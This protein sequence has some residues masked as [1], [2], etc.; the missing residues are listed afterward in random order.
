MNAPLQRSR[1]RRFASS[2]TILTTLSA[3]ILIGSVVAHGV[4][5]QDRAVDSRDAAT[6]SVP[7]PRN[8]G[9]TF[10]KIFNQVGPAVVNIN[11]ETLPKQPQTSRRGRGMQ[12]MNPDQGQGQGGDDDDNGGGDDSGNQGGG[13]N[14]LQDFFNRFFGGMPGPGNGGDMQDQEQRALGSGFIV[15]PRGYI[16]T[17]NH[18]VDKA[19][20]IYVK[21]TTDPVN[22]QGHL[23]KVIGVDTATDLAVIKIDVGHP[24]PTVQLGNSD[25][26]E[27]GEWVEAIGSPF[28]LSQTVTAGIVSAKNRTIQQGVAGQFQHFIQTD[29]AINPGNSG[30]PLLNMDGQVIGVNTAIFTQSNG[31]MG[32]GFAMPSNTVIDVYNQLIGPEHKVVRGSIGISFQPNINSAIAK[33]YDASSGVLISAVVPGGPADKA[34]LKPN[35]VIVSID[36]KTIKD[37][38]ELVNN[39][40]ARH[41]GSTVSIGYLRSG[42]HM[43]TT[44]T[45]V[46]RNKTVNGMMASNGNGPAPANPAPNVSQTKLGMSVSDLPPNAPS[47]FHGVLI[48]SIKPGSFADELGS[49][50]AEGYSGLQPGDIIEAVN[51]KPIHNKAEFDSIVST[52]KSGDDVVFEIANPHFGA[53]TTLVGGVLP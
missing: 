25:S 2:F 6:L 9:T 8:L 23:A 14:G 10:T 39:I 43:T 27:V 7:A 40:S 30:G 42:Q 19:D 3:G 18:V 15:D 52:L 38:D 29:A 5:G 22:D 48:Q 44:V 26:T 31:Y 4:H 35:D 46:D 51:R 45:I 13:D 1:I 20:R 28:D 24:L 50:S 37:G 36:G 17:N 47:G 21:L 53:S 16:I 34:G 49:T 41:P 33:M 11:T 12:Q 32:I